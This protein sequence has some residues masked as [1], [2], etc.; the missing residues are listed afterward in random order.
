M[1]F[2][3]PVFSVGWILALTVAILAVLL[4]ALGRLPMEWTMGIVA[5]CAVRL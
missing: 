1:T 4:F 2:T 5:L 3:A